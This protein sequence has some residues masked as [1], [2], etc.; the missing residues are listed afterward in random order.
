MTSKGYYNEI[1]VL[2]NNSSKACFLKV[3]HTRTPHEYVTVC[4]IVKK[5]NLL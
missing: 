3:Y 4:F 2:V 1:L 5:Q